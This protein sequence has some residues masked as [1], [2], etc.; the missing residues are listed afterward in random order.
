MKRGFLNTSRA[1][2]L[3][4][5][6]YAPR[7][8]PEPSRQTKTSSPPSSRRTQDGGSEAAAT[9]DAMDVDQTAVKDTSS[10]TEGRIVAVSQVRSN[11]DKATPPS[12]ADS[13]EDVNGTSAKA[14]QHPE[15]ND[16]KGKGAGAVDMEDNHIKATMLHPLRNTT[17]PPR[18]PPR[19]P[20]WGRDPKEDFFHLVP[21]SF[22]GPHRKRTVFRIWPRDPKGKSLKPLTNNTSGTLSP[23][24]YAWAATLYDLYC[25]DSVPEVPDAA[26]IMTG[27]ALCEAM[28]ELGELDAA[29]AEIEWSKSEGKPRVL[30][31]ANTEE[32]IRC[33]DMRK[34]DNEQDDNGDEDD[35]DK[36]DHDGEDGVPPPPTIPVTS[37]FHPNHCPKPFVPFSNPLSIILQECIPLYLL[38][39]TLHVHDPF[40]LLPARERPFLDT[41]WTSRPDIIRTYNLKLSES[42]CRV[43][44]GA[45]VKAEELEEFKAR[46]LIILRYQ[47]TKEQLKNHEPVIEVPLPPYQR[48]ITKVEE[49]H[50]YVSP[51][52]KV[53]EGHHSIVY[54]GEW[55]LPREMFMKTRICPL[56][57]KESADKEIQRLKDTGRWQKLT[58]A[59]AWDLKGFTGRQPTEAELD[60]VKDPSNLARDGE[61]IAREV[62]CFV[63]PN[64]AP[65]QV[66]EF[67]DEK[68]V[69]NT[70]MKDRSVNAM[71]LQFTQDD[72][73][74]PA[75]DSHVT[76]IRINPPF[77]YES[78][79][80]CTHEKQIFPSPV[81][82]TTKF[83]VVAKLSLEDDPHL[84]REASNYQ[85]FPEHFFHHYNGYTIINQ[86]HTIVPVSAIVPQF[87][88]YYV[89][90]K[91]KEGNPDQPSYLSPILLLEHCGKPIEPKKLSIEDQEECAS[92]L[93][94]FQRAGWLH[95]SVAPRNFLVQLGKPTEFPPVRDNNPETSFRLIDFGRSRKY[96]TEREKRRE[97][98]EVLKMFER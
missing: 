22:G 45:R 32:V 82:R 58:R 78:Q 55:E 37:P 85:R 77:S 60:E 93:L 31:V 79:K 73:D 26:S 15:V 52:A 16:V 75:K 9:Q 25:V 56:C 62:T 29:A 14:E 95:E 97:V 88:G 67:L 94:R 87:Y 81:P 28:E 23:D 72:E 13:R 2:R 50:L 51:V 40:C 96:E 49:S 17:I 11:A 63:P 53:G 34:Q 57:F 7:S 86:F 39:Q 83:T 43:V 91:D 89:P 74:E 47:R 64:I 33:I 3:I 80:S 65:A 18:P 36:E 4:E 69:W 48:R 61:I 30:G 20:G 44:E 68:D 5:E 71:H 54:K 42:V 1:K 6:A 24:G 10:N 46:T 92:M 8:P 35:G 84:A 19:R 66:V 98:K 90:K 70:L 76:S 27:S 21:P 38:P 41:S 59:V 12:Q